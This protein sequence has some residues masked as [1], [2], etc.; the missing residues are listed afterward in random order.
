MNGGRSFSTNDQWLFQ[1]AEEARFGVCLA[2]HR[3]TVRYVNYYHLAHVWRNPRILS[4]QYAVGQ[5]LGQ[6]FPPAFSRQC[7]DLFAQVLAAGRWTS[8]E[9]GGDSGAR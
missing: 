4:H 8:I 7:E 2:D 6:V 3:K 1:I 9:D 5:P